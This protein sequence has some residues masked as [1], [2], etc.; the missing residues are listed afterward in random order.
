MFYSALQSKTLENLAY[1]YWLIFD[2]KNFFFFKLM[3]VQ[4][5]V[6]KNDKHQ[7]LQLNEG[8]KIY[9]GLGHKILKK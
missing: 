5:I 2:K 6:L 3:T 8:S 7:F 1:W 9:R 4:K